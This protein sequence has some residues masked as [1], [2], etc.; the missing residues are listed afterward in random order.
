MRQNNHVGHHLSYD[1]GGKN[2]NGVKSRIPT[3]TAAS[4][5]SSRGSNQPEN[6]RFEN[7]RHV[8]NA[9]ASRFDD[10]DNN[11]KSKY[12][13]K[14]NSI[15]KR[16]KK[17]NDNEV[18]SPSYYYAK[19]EIS[20]R[21]LPIDSL[22]AKAMHKCFIEEIYDVIRKVVEKP[23]CAFSLNNGKTL[24]FDASN[25]KYIGFEATLTVGESL[26][27]PVN[28][29]LELCQAL[30]T[31]QQGLVTL[32]S[33]QEISQEGS[34]SGVADGTVDGFWHR[35]LHSHYEKDQGDDAAAANDGGIGKSVAED[36]AAAITNK[37][38][39]ALSSSFSE[40]TRVLCHITPID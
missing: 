5:S 40:N 22:A 20:T 4:S 29:V 37:E 31:I 32:K 23:N 24:I 30:M 19:E 34:N 14:R 26:A 13:T 36:D 10:H 18:A 3:T 39:E 33:Y 11:G 6:F 8:N 16:R 1:L 21:P 25:L 28:N 35:H 7:S 9:D 38:E 12:S 17:K 15:K 2:K 27:F